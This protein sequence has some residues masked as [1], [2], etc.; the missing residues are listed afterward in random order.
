M[1]AFKNPVY[2]RVGASSVPFA[3][4]TLEALP[5]AQEF[6]LGLMGRGTVS[7]PI[8]AHYVRLAARLKRQGRLNMP[9][10]ITH[11]TER[12]AA[13]AYWR[14]VSESYTAR[15]SPV[16][17]A[18]AKS[19]FVRTAYTWIRVHALVPPVIP[20]KDVK[21]IPRLTS[22]GHSSLDPVTREVVVHEAPRVEWVPTTAWTLH[23]PHKPAPPH[24]DPCPDCAVIELDDKGV[25]LQVLATAFESA[26]GHRDLSRVPADAL[27]F[28][29]PP[30]EDAQVVERTVAPAGRI[31]ALM[32]PSQLANDVER[33]GGSVVRE[34]D[35][36]AARARE[37]VPDAVVISRASAGARLEDVL[38]VVR[39][40]WGGG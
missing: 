36:F 6:L 24:E 13:N 28:G 7:L 21:R 10:A 35:M 26:W 1:P 34:L 2:L 15:L 25:Q 40:V 27:L 19:D 20:G 22:F 17:R 23:V 33:L 18:F 3:P 38:A 30:R 5:D 32:P 12:T 4:G 37:V 16:L 14:W 8:A 11:N 9:A 39:A 29:A 31:V